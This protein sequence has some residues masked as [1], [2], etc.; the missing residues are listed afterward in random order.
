MALGDIVAR[1]GRDIVQKLLKR[2]RERSGATVVI[3][4]G[5]NAAGG[6]GI[7]PQCAKEIFAAGVDLIT[8]GDHV[9]RRREAEQVLERT[10]VRVIRPANF[11]PGAPGMGWMRY[12][13]SSSHEIGVMNL[14]GRTFI[15]G[16]LDCP[17]RA[18][19]RIL[20]DHLSDCAVIICDMHAEATSEKIAMG[21]HLDGRASLV[22]GTHTHVQTA[23]E[24]ILP[25]GTG[26]ITDLGMCGSEEGV[27][28]LRED[29]ALRR[30]L[31]GL[32]AGYKPAQGREAVRGIIA[33]ISCETGKCV[34]IE[35]VYER[36]EAAS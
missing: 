6:S 35:R 16:S 26:Y 7:D 34:S 23:D 20:S 31:S 18:A 29:I 13:V 33:E 1:P 11:P 15:G 12:G 10:P 19:D 2:L 21:R 28:G 22:F 17:F 3:A 4:N 5:E 30:F 14:I 9:W 25:A 27:I 24:S 8:L 32:P 36:E